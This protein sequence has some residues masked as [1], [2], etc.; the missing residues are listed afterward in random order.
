MQYPDKKL[1]SRFLELYLPVSE[2]DRNAN[3]SLTWVPL[4]CERTNPS[5]VLRLSLHALAASRVAHAEN[6]VFLGKESLKC[7]GDALKLLQKML[8]VP[9][10]QA[11][12]EVLAACRCLMLFEVGPILGTNSMSMLGPIAD[13]VT[14]S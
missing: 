11:D 13:N 10:P 6:D 9:T 8:S 4:A 5:P 12:D 1:L 2:V 3:G 7:Y 14:Y